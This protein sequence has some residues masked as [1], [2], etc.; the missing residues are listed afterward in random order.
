MKDL[1]RKQR[2]EDLEA[3]VEACKSVD[4]LSVV[5]DRR[6]DR[7]EWE[8]ALRVSPRQQPAVEGE[9]GRGRDIGRAAL[10][11]IWVSGSLLQRPLCI[12]IGHT[13]TWNIVHTKTPNLVSVSTSSYLHVASPP[14]VASPP[15]GAC[16]SRAAPR[17]A[18]AAAL[19]VTR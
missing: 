17:R 16:G 15:V 3:S 10:A 9:M 14:P 2:F 13:V 5:K 18:R 11:C 4:E 7:A 19:C 12:T 8:E 1:L 6:D